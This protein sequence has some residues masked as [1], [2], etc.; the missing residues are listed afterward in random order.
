MSLEHLLK[1]S[2]DFPVNVMFFLF[3]VLHFLLCLNHFSIFKDKIKLKA[4]IVQ[5]IENQD[6]DKLWI[7][8]VVSMLNPVRLFEYQNSVLICFCLKQNGSTLMGTLIFVVQFSQYTLVRC[9]AEIKIHDVI[10]KYKHPV[11]Q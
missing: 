7:F 5:I 10:V 3:N 6:S 9:L 8:F 2:F 11:P 4:V 1:L